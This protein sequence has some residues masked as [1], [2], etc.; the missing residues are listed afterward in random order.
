CA[1]IRRSA[2]GAV[3]DRGRKPLGTAVEVVRGERPA[4]HDV[5]DEN[6]PQRVAGKGLAPVLRLATQVDGAVSL[7]HLDL[8][9]GRGRQ[10]RLTAPLLE[11]QRL[12]GETGE[13]GFEQRFDGEITVLN[14]R[15]IHADVI[16]MGSPARNAPAP[17]DL[18]RRLIFPLVRGTL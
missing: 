18:L 4:G 13:A 5:M 17:R 11:Q 7:V 9:V 8:V 14:Q 10:T 1:P 15:W 3:E 2:A 12:V 6:L 16:A